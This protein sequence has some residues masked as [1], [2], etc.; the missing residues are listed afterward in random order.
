MALRLIECVAPANAEEHI[1]EIVQKYAVVAQWSRQ[2]ADGRR[3]VQILV[4]ARETES[5]LDEL[6]SYYA[7]GPDFRVLLTPVEATVPRPEEPEPEDLP[8]GEDEPPPPPDRISREELYAQAEA[9]VGTGRSYYL[10]VLLSSLVAAIGLVRSDTAV[11]IGAMVIAPLLGPNMALA[12]ATTLGDEKLAR[13]A[14]VANVSGLG[15]AVLVSLAFGSFILLLGHDPTA[16]ESLLARATV[17]YAD[18]ILALASGCAGALAFTKNASGTLVGVMV[19]VAL[20]PPAVSAVML[21]VGGEFRL[22]GQ[23]VLLFVTNVIG[24]NLSAVCT[25]LLSGIRPRTWWEA[26]RARRASRRA[27][28]AWILLLAILVTILSLD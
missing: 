21:F 28:T 2:L 3:E 7:A 15:F 16:S 6:E 17:G 20:L 26:D 18:V 23:A 25:F 22:A 27:I 13:K 4:D 10:T 8:T 24:V 19:A 11:I 9:G 14:F 12:L 5:I 1:L